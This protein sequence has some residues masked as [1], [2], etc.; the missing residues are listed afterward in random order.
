[1]P[2][3]TVLKLDDYRERRD[4]R[5]RLATS[6]HRADPGRAEL[7]E[8]IARLAFLVNAD[9][10]ATVWV[11]EYG[12]GL[13]HPHVVLDLLNDRPRRTFSIEPLR[14][15]W[16]N[17]VPGVQESGGW[18]K[19]DG[20]PWTLAVAL[21]SDGSRSWFLVADSVT[22]RPAIG[23]ALRDLV[24]FVA[25]ECSAVVLHRDLDTALARAGTDGR[26]GRPRFAGWPILQDIEGREHDERV[27]RRVAIRFIVARL[28]RLLVEDDM[29]IPLDRL[30]LQAQ[31]ARDEIEAKLE[32]VEPDAETQ[33]WS[34]VLDAFQSGDLEA[35]GAAL[36]ELGGTVEGHLHLHG[37][38]ELYALAYEMFAA[39]GMVTAAVE[40]ARFAGRAQRRLAR[41]DEAHRW[42]G[43]ARDVAKTA[44]LEHKV[45]VV[46]DGV[47]NI[48]RDRGNHPA[49]RETLREALAY[50]ER[51]GNRTAV[52]R[53]HHGFLALEHVAGNL[54]EAIAHGW[55]AI[56]TYPDSQDQVEGLASLA[57][58]LID[59][60]ELQAAEDAWS[61]V[62][63]LS[64][65][66][67]Y[68]IFSAEA[69]AYVAALQGRR[70]EWAH[71]AGASDARGWESGPEV[72]KAEVL[73]MRA[74][75][76][77]ALGHDAEARRWVE[78]CVAYAEKK[79]FG[80]TVF[81]AEAVLK[82]LETSEREQ[83]WEA[84]T[85][86]VP[87]TTLDLRLG[88]QQ[89]RREATVHAPGPQLPVPGWIAAGSGLNAAGSGLNAAGSGLNA[90]GS[91]LDAA[92]SGLHPA[93]SRILTIGGQDGRSATRGGADG[94]QQDRK[95]AANGLHNLFP[96]GWS[97]EGRRGGRTATVVSGIWR[98][99]NGA[100]HHFTVRVYLFRRSCLS[101]LF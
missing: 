56:R 48:H 72:A 13:V 54:G 65:Q 57:G 68:Q 94:E 19:A 63:L 82:S 77:A 95:G 14:R 15:A 83:A 2:N 12:P 84:P 11:D 33:L 60:G 73:L 97:A 71:R 100:S 79:G 26:Q 92:G 51:S 36:L 85:A 50:A 74:Q 7:M 49:A 78:R 87:P 80:R 6:L 8:H 5:L 52:G 43:L 34:E 16:E 31:R 58:A 10:V 37:A 32:G 35:L 89:M 99:P 98:R 76:H 66:E 29:A 25:G 64:G 70:T 62:G 69:L 46:L 59:A 61:I 81:D 86:A 17:G 91:G 24:M 55:E 27:G 75:S 21:G 88:L 38:T 41:W 28:P 22:P 23:S 1:M 67:Y 96:D 18:S 93:A 40:A 47:A 42:Y 90:A 44:S 101:S 53:I 9:R 45:A 4:L 3:S 30:R 20:S 39:S